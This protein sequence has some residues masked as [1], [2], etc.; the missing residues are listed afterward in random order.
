MQTKYISYKYT[1]DYLLKF[2][3][4]DSLKNVAC[5]E[6]NH[7]YFMKFKQTMIYHKATMQ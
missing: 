4:P 3:I 2:T 7:L 1:E 5:R 6:S